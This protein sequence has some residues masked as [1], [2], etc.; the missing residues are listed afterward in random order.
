MVYYERIDDSEGIDVNKTIATKKCI[1]FHFCYFS[2]KGFRFQST[3]FNG[4]YNILMVSIDIKNITV[5]NINGLDYRFII[6]GICKSEAINLLK[7]ANFSDKSG[8]L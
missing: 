1:I 7:N 4:C 5:L 8:S 2:D 3:S 6:V